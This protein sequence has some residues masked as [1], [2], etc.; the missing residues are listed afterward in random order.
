MN[1][2]INSDDATLINY[3]F[4]GLWVFSDVIWDPEFGPMFIE[5]HQVKL[6]WKR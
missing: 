1:T 4:Y 5:A 3:P 6:Q 2:I